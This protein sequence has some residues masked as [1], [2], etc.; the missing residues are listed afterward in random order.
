VAVSCKRDNEPP[1]S[2]NGG[3]FLDYVSI[4]S[5]YQGLRREKSGNKA[6]MVVPV[7]VCKILKETH[8]TITNHTG[9][10]SLYIKQRAVVRL[11][12]FT[13]PYFR[14]LCFSPLLLLGLQRLI[15]QRH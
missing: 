11:H 7:S 14:T 3:E 9:L 13:A 15:C 6:N 2:I 8:L 5:T 1:G 4:L 12:Y 10:S